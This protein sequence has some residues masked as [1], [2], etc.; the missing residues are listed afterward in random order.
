MGIPTGIP[1]P[2]FIRRARATSG[3]RFT[4]GLRDLMTHDFAVVPP[5]SND[6]TSSAPT[7]WPISPATRAPA[8]GPDSI[9]WIGKATAVSTVM[10]PPLEVIR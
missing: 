9:S 8:A 2:F 7:C 6:T 1:L 4:R 5:M 3:D 10:V